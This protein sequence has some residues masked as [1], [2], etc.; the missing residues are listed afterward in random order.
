M[1]FE[2]PVGSVV[3]NRP[4]GQYWTAN[5]Q[6]G[7]SGRRTLPGDGR[8]QPVRAGCPDPAMR[9]TKCLEPSAWFVG[10]TNPTGRT[11]R[12]VQRPVV[13]LRG[14][15]YLGTHGRGGARPYRIPKPLRAGAGL[16]PRR[17]T[18][19]Q[20]PPGPTARARSAQD[21]QPG[22]LDA[23]ARGGCKGANQM[24]GKRQKKTPGR[25]ITLVR[26][27]C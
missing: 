15:K 22:G 7:S 2:S 1:E 4:Y 10:T 26:G 6:H 21:N 24:A 19:K 12:A 5:P 20:K 17:G 11:G 14:R 16:V 23:E 13:G 25:A 18:K 8:R 9:W 3:P 27:F